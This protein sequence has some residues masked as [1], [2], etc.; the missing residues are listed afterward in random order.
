[1]ICH[2]VYWVAIADSWPTQQVLR[3]CYLL[4][5]FPDP[6]RVS[7]VMLIIGRVIQAFGGGAMVPVGMALAGD[8][9]RQ[10]SGQTARHHRR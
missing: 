7:L 4:H 10:G 9:Y 8:L 1:V 3:L 2:R 6:P 5:F